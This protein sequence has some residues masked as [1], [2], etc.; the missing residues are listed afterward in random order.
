MLISDLFMTL[1]TK[2][3]FWEGCTAITTAILALSTIITLWVTIHYSKKQVNFLQHQLNEEK[4][5]HLRQNKQRAHDCARNFLQDFPI[6]EIYCTFE[7][8]T[9]IINKF[10]DNIERM[11]YEINQEDLNTLLAI[12]DKAFIY[13]TK[14]LD[15]QR[16]LK[17]Y[18]KEK[19]PDRFKE[20]DASLGPLREAFEGLKKTIFDFL[21]IQKVKN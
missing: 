15:K 19:C 12:R 4:E 10:A 20:Y 14:L 6:D 5:K 1:F 18:E 3:H 11:K 2:E 8:F 16:C 17:N 13:R 7:E 9:V 21:D